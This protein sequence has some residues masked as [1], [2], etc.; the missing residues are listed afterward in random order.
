[1]DAL[2]LLEDHANGRIRMERSF[3][4]HGDFLAHDDDWL[5]SRFR[6]PRAV[7]LDLCAELGPVLDRPTRRNRTIP[8][9][10]QVLT[11]LGFLATGSFQQELADRSGISQPSLSAI[12]PAVLDGIIKMTSRYIRFPYTVGEQADIKRQFAE[13]ERFNVAHSRTRS[14]VER[15]F[16]L[17]KA[18]W[19]CLDAS[20]G[21][22]LYH[23]TK[24]CKIIMACG[25]LHNVALGNAVPLPHGL[26]PPHHE[27]PDPQPP[28]R[29]E[30]FQQ[31]ARLREDVMRRLK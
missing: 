3:R 29:H 27:D 21:R 2:A 15:A 14:V 12:M 19:R 9:H 22:L 16:G 18:R 4:D 7:L 25:V 8:V 30:E 28:P 31:G 26:P 24:V 10:I 17:L 23:P 11:T 13:E 20:G 6:F 1:M 5:I